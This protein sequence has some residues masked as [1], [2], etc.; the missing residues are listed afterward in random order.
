MVET[1]GGAAGA[2]AFLVAGVS[3]RLGVRVNDY[4]FKVHGYGLWVM[5][6]GLWV[7]SL[8]LMVDG[9]WF[10]VRFMG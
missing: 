2:V 7:N 10:G 5:G 6:Y 9:Y 3:L 8:W 1:S 4:Q